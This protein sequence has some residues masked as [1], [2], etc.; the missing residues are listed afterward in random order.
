VERVWL[1]ASRIAP[2]FVNQMVLEADHGDLSAIDWEAALARTHE[3]TPGMGLVLRGGLGWS[4]WSDTVAPRVRR[5]SGESWRGTDGG[6]APF[7]AGLLEPS[8]GPT[9][10]VVVC[11][12]PSPRVVL[13]T[14]HAT[15]DG[16]G[17]SLVAQRLFAAARGEP[18]EPLPPETVTD[19]EL[20]QT[21]GVLP[22]PEPSID[23]PAVFGEVRAAPPLTRWVRRDV[24]GAPGRN[25]LARLAHAL[26][27]RVPESTRSAA[28]IDVP[29]DMRRHR[30]ELVSTANL[31]GLIRLPAGAIVA[32][33]GG[34]LELQG[35]LDSA[36]SA[37]EEAGF[38]LSL[39]SVRWLPLALMA[40][41]GRRAASQALLRGRFS[42]TATVSNLG[43]MD[44]APFQAPGFA[45]QRAF[46]IPPGSPGLPL[47]LT[48]TGYAGGLTLCGTA[49]LGLADG[50]RLEELMDHL[51]TVLRPDAADR[52]AP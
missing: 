29:V 50:G 51:V 14:A 43:R 40:W 32:D 52:S 16:R 37:R 24:T 22:S 4:T 33:G 2:P 19:A 31:T 48:V 44:L 1:T 12:G 6:G 8:R 39:R 17:T 28:R 23:C 36:L 7:L 11:E 46:F 30:A 13:R 34:A 26:T 15:M 10:E 9:V 42:T 3:T 20:A 27:L 49:P 38:P 21:L 35:A 45:A 25:V 41:G 47:F 18:L 5:V